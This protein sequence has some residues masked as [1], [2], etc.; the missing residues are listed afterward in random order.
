MSNIYLVKRQSIR[1]DSCKQMKL[2]LT[3]CSSRFTPVK[4]TLV[5]TIN[6]SRVTTIPACAGWSVHAKFTYVFFHDATQIYNVPL[7]VILDM[8]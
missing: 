5:S 6:T 1:P 8:V 2:I 7:T 4:P 3:I